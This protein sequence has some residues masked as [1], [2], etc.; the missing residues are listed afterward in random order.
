M[1]WRAGLPA[2]GRLFRLAAGLCAAAPDEERKAK[3]HKCARNGPAHC[4]AKR[5][6]AALC[7]LD[8]AARA[9]AVAR[10]AHGKIVA[11]VAQRA[12]GGQGIAAAAGGA[13]TGRVA[14]RRGGAH[15]AGAQGAARGTAGSASD[16]EWVA[17]R[18]GGVRGRVTVDGVENRDGNADGQRLRRDDR[19]STAASV[20]GM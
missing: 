15:D 6:C 13:D 5:P 8:A 11:V 10:V 7:L 14:L 2:N 4:T 20:G 3:H 18:G 16:R 12:S 1:R 17:C 19:R 9:G